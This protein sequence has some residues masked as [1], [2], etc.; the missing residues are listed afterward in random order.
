[1]ADLV[2]GDYNDLPRLLLAD[3]PGFEQ[4][5]EFGLIAEHSDLPGVVVA[6][7]GRYLVRLEQE[8]RRAAE[9]SAAD[10][11]YQVFERMA[12]SEDP[13]I[14]NALVVEVFENLDGSR[15]ITRRIVKRLGPSSQALYADWVGAN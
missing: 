11:V 10:A 9:P 8:G 5:P 1:V 4:S 2:P 12:T 14:Q 15:S 6:A 3:V 13:E 7:V